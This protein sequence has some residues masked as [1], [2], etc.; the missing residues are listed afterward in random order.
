MMAMQDRISDLNLN[1]SSKDTVEVV[2]DGNEEGEEGAFNPEFFEEV[3][4]IKSLMS[5]MRRNVKSI[6]TAYS[7]QGFAVAENTQKTEELESLLES[8]NS[9]ASKVRNKLKSMK[10][11][12]DTLPPENPQKRVQTNMHSVLSEKFRSLLTEYQTL[13]TNYKEKCRDRVQRQAE[14][15]KPGVTREEVDQMIE[16]G[17]GAFQD[18]MLSTQKHTEA[19]NALM[20]MQE[21]QRDLKQLE[22]SIQEL[23]QIFLDMQSVV[24]SQKEVV[25]RVETNV[26]ESAVYTAESIHKLNKAHEYTMAKRRRIAATTGAIVVILLV[27]AGI[28]GALFAAKVFA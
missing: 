8:T 28:I 9:A 12:N 7:K 1:R 5:L 18:Q 2:V 24:E 19:K 26:A 21:Q 20:Q 6:Q 10:H 4:Q 15:V 22:K 17:T 23:H 25:D 11:R 13:Q 27:A 3:G 16:T 14:I